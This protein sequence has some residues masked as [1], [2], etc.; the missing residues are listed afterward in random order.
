MSLYR[1]TRDVKRSGD[2]ATW[3]VDARVD[4]KHLRLCTGTSDRKAAEAID[5]AIK[6]RKRGFNVDRV[7][8]M[9]RLFFDTPA[10]SINDQPKL[11][12]ANLAATAEEYIRAESKSR[13]LAP[14]TIAARISTCQRFAD[15]IEKDK[16]GL[17][18]RLAEVTANLAYSFVSSLD[19]IST[20]R[21]QN[22]VG[23]LS[24]VWNT[25]LRA[26]L[27]SNNPWSLA[28]PRANAAEA[29]HGTAFTSEEIA[30]ILDESRRIVLLNRRGE[31]SDE[32]SEEP[33]DTWLTVAIMI[34]VYTGFRQGD[35]LALRWSDVD[36]GR[37]VI[38]IMPSKTAR[39]KRRVVVPMHKALAEFLF[40]LERN[41][42]KVVQNPP[43]RAY[44]AWNACVARA[45]ITRQ[46]KE[47]VSF[48]S[49][50]HTY[51]TMIR[52]AGA[53]KGEQMLLGGWTNVATANRYDH[54][55]TKLAKI[56]SLL[57]DIEKQ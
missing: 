49:L 34:A 30:R 47:L 51:A 14:A 11:L 52:H 28:R 2:K 27:V 5:F 16:H 46:D 24:A 9:I 56:V 42:D 36:F 17:I 1:K 23:D 35:V 50:R 19:K 21:Q 39:F 26:G 25:L 4:G 53:D 37:N 10:V 20:K 43:K 45:G 41:G 33:R 40:G 7:C 29:K 12:V 31:V 57:P 48:H 15:W 22:I 38:D 8:E 32:R 55:L 13:P 54:D 3:Y 44:F 6:Q 18:K